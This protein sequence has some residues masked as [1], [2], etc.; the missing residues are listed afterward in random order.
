LSYKITAIDF[1]SHYYIE[2]VSCEN[3]ANTCPNLKTDTRLVEIPTM[4]H[5]HHKP[6]TKHELRVDE[7]TQ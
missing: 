5:L 1:A 3:F 7:I 4:T 2:Y 6:C